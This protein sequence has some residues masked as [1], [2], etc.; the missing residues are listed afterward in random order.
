[1]NLL[2]WMFRVELEKYSMQEE[3]KVKLMKLKDHLIIEL[4][5]K[6]LCDHEDIL[7]S[8]GEKF[9]RYEAAANY[10][11]Y[12]ELLIQIENMGIDELKEFCVDDSEELMNMLN[13]SKYIVY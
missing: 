13:S 8:R 5:E 11:E 7:D 1:M 9:S 2:E 6:L 10:A 4:K 3:M 12:A